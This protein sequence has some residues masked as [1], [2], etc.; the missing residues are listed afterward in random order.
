MIGANSNPKL[1]S[2]VGPGQPVHLAQHNYWIYC[3]GREDRH[4]E[5]AKH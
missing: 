1:S 5:A 2:E 4:K 3:Y